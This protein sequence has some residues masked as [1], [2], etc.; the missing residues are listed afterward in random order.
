MSD[1]L[2]TL[3]NSNL[4]C[5]IG[6]ANKFK[7]IGLTD[8][9]KIGINKNKYQ[10]VYLDTN[11]FYLDFTSYKFKGYPVVVDFLVNTYSSITTT[12]ENTNGYELHKAELLNDFKELFKT[13]N[14]VY[15]VVFS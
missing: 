15:T 4:A 5:K 9:N 14:I 6:Q 12:W 7:T 10:K 8:N 13:D 2:E 1:L 3:Q 11:N